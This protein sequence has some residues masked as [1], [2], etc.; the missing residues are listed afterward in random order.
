VVKTLFVDP[1]RC[2][3]CRACEA[4]CREC[5]SHKGESMVMVDF[6]DRSFS[7]ATQPTVCMHCEDPI[8]PCAQSCPVM[9]ILVTPEGVV[10]QADP[11]RCIACQNCVFACPFG[12]PKIDLNA[13][14]MKKCNLCYDRTA[15]GLQPWC[16]QACPT[17]A[18]WYGDYEEFS[19]KRKGRAVRHTVFGAQEV[20]TR[21]FHVLPEETQKLDV[22]KL[23]A[24]AR[25]E[26]GAP[27]EGEE[28]WIV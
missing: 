8:A 17:S 20:R 7:V 15:E 19:Q 6:L 2:I 3:G 11:S 28:A 10:Q 1:S 5:D 18:L 9:A 26:A 25:A 4:A 22:V 23:L 24:D 16:A 27:A 21:V 14:L 12:V 13:R